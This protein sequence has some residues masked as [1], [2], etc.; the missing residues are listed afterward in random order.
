MK[1]DDLFHSPFFIKFCDRYVYLDIS[2][3][4]WQDWHW[5]M[6]KSIKIYPFTKNKIEKF[7]ELLDVLELSNDSRW[8][9]APDSELEKIL[10]VWAVDLSPYLINQLWRLKK[11][12][13]ES[14]FKQMINWLLPTRQRLAFYQKQPRFREGM[15][16]EERK[17]SA[18]SGLP[19]VMS[20][21]Y[22]NR[23]ILR[24]ASVCPVS[25][26]FCFR[27][28]DVANHPELQAKINQGIS[29]A[30]DYI[31][32][33]NKDN[34]RRCINDVILSGGD[35]LSLSDDNLKKIINKIGEIKGVEIIRI[36]TKFPACLPQRITDDFV[37]YLG[38]ISREKVVIMNIHFTHPG[39]LSSEVS[40]ACFKL[41][42]AGVILGAHTPLLKNINDNR[43]T[44]KILFQNLLFMRVRPYYLIQYIQTPGANHFQVSPQKGL[45]LIKYI[46]SEISGPA[47]PH[48]ILYTPDGGGKVHLQ[49]QYLVEE[50]PDG[51]V[52]DTWQGRN[53]YPRLE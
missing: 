21:L 42:Q 23:V 33:W 1:Q 38:N 35:P 51:W 31:Q 5:Q 10:N 17:K 37:K 9:D 26:Q 8:K 7:K 48:Y 16:T 29:E 12:G 18:Y 2:D 49:P 45:E 20:R 46:E 28:H 52:I 27:Q 6:A 39:E 4:D 15:G 47:Q 13:F 32:R 43:E 34:P 25:C 44:L 50:R 41:N 19:W 30:I 14:W 24:V 53:F 40:K 11:Q 22:D 3:I 36:D